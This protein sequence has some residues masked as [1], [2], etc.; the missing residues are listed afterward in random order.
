MKTKE[1]EG[2]LVDESVGDSHS[3]LAWEGFLEASLMSTM[4]DYAIEADYQTG[5]QFGKA[6][7]VMALKTWQRLKEKSSD[8]VPF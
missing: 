3:Q 7:E 6:M 2:A 8:E 1:L 4:A 5:Y